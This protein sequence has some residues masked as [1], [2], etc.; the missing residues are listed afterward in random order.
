MAHET[1]VHRWDAEAAVTAASAVDADLAPDGIEELLEVFLY[2]AAASLPGEGLG[3]S[4][5]LRCTDVAGAWVIRLAK[6]RAEVT[7]DEGPATATLSGT[8]SELL[9]FL[10]NRV[11]PVHLGLEGS[12]AVA[13]AWPAFLRW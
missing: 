12:A 1:A 2:E 6:R 13:E 11:P 7:P 4:L 10:W 9:L 8:A 5:G 3:G